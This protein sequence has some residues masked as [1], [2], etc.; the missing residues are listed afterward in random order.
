MCC[1]YKTIK[2]NKMKNIIDKKADTNYEILP[3]IA[4]RWSPVLFSDKNI[5]EDRLMQIFEA[6]RWAP[7]SRNEQPWRFIYAYKG[8]PDFNKMID[9]LMEGNQDWAKEVPVIVIVLSEKFSS[10]NG[11]PMFH[12]MYDTGAASM[13]MQLQALELGIYSHTMGGFFPEK[14]KELF[15]IPENLE[16]V[17]FVAFGY[18]TNEFE[19]R[20]SHL[21]ERDKSPRDRKPLSD[22]VFKGAI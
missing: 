14:T 3:L 16:I 6:A 17:S 7:S 15:N 9:S 2:F 12:Y 5:E 8:T 18:P 20:P 10:F 4:K 19:K 1:K 21:Q 13:Q 22:I 11:E